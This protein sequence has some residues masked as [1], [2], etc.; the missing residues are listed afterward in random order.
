M[1]QQGKDALL[2]KA[3]ARMRDKGRQGLRRQ[4]PKP[5]RPEQQIRHYRAR[6]RELAKAVEDATRDELFPIVD[7]LIDQA[8]TRDDSARADG[9]QDELRD[10][11]RVVR[12]RLDDEVE[13]K[14]RAMEK[15]ADSVQQH[16]TDDQI[17]AIRAVLGVEPDFYDQDRVQGLLQA[18]KDA[19]GAHIKSMADDA[20]KG[21]Q[22]DASRAV[23]QGKTTRD[24]K[25]RLRKRFKMTDHRAKRIARTEVSQLNAHITRSRQKDVGIN[26]YTWETAGDERVRDE[27]EYM[28]GRDVE[29]DDPPAETGG[30]HAGEPVNCRCSSRA[31]VDKLLDELESE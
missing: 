11:M 8:G 6:L 14:R 7:S 21:I 23:R 19:N 28:Q 4:P 29:W 10:R 13:G 5:K 12:N 20:V 2:D 22:D 9:W 18:W 26:S 16:A 17:K 1:S 24:V 31:S 25:D 3:R 27:H 15:L 30:Q